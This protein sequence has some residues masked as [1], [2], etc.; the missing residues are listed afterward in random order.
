MNRLLYGEPHPAEI[1]C[2]TKTCSECGGI[3]EIYWALNWVT[4][5]STQVTKTTYDLLPQ[6]E[7]QAIKAGQRYYQIEIEQ[8]P[9]CQ[10][11]GY[12]EL[13]DINP[14]ED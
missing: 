3:G 7:G 14:W 2:R 12:I 8:C 10:G 1:E 9:S 6:T 11:R 4:N 13:E 5:N